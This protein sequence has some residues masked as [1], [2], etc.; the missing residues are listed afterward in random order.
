MPPEEDF[1]LLAAHQ[2]GVH[3]PRMLQKPQ[4]S[5]VD[6]LIFFPFLLPPPPF[7]FPVYTCQEGWHVHPHAYACN[8]TRLLPTHLLAIFKLQIPKYRTIFRSGND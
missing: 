2:E 3:P 4:I 6:L 8:S 5:R 1:N 7:I